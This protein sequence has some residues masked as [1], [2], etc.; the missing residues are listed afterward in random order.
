MTVTLRN[1]DRLTPDQVQSATFAP[2]R[3]GRRGYDEE[4]VRAFRDQ[5]RRELVTLLN[6][7]TT[8]REEVDRLRGH[9]RGATDDEGFSGY[10]PEDGHI[11]AVRILSSAQQTADRYVADAQQYSRALAE[12]ARR[13]RDEVLAAARQQAERL[14]DEAHGQASQAAAIALSSP[15][16]L[17][18]GERRELQAQLVYLR[19]FS[20]VYRTHLR[21]Y[22]DALVRNVDEWERAEKSSIN[23]ARA[24][25]RIP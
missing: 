22:L 13:H 17:P 18:A 23:A 5:V 14:L 1:D 21:A 16:S 6:E 12:D 19:T 20:D 2:A 3:F 15:D 4:N 25:L 9:M 11:Q 7:R 8:L 24:D 10:R